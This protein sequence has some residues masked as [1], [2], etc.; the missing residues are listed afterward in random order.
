V[1]AEGSPDLTVDGFAEQLTCGGFIGF[2]F[3][4][5]LAEQ[6]AE[7]LLLVLGSLT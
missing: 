3:T 2:A 5:K 7:A 4:V 6:V 1:I